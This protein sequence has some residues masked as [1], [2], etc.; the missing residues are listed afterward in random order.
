MHPFPR[1]ANNVYK[2]STRW[3]LV[4]NL[5]RKIIGIIIQHKH[6]RDKTDLYLSVSQ[7]KSVAVVIWIVQ[8]VSYVSSVHASTRSF[9]SI[10]SMSFLVSFL[11]LLNWCHCLGRWKPLCTPFPKQIFLGTLKQEYNIHYMLLGFMLKMEVPCALT[12]P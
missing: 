7:I 12:C 5:L 6:N 9:I 8:S 11:G 2:K 1:Y 4:N 10:S 3:V